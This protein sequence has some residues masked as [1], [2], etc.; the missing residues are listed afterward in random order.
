MHSR[1]ENQ[2][3]SCY[4]TPVTPSQTQ[5]PSNSLSPTKLCITFVR[6][7]VKAIYLWGE[8]YSGRKAVGYLQIVALLVWMMSVI[9]QSL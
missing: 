1:A 8:L 9:A 2:N 4:H 3:N 5:T 6:W 7:N